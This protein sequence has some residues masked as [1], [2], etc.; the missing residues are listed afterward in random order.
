VKG[1]EKK[2]GD[3]VDFFNGLCSKVKRCYRASNTQLIRMGESL[4]KSIKLG[5]KSRLFLS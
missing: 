4:S 5:K 2:L 3:V 1:W